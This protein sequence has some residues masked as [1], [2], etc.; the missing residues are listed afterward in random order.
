MSNTELPKKG[1]YKELA[2]NKVMQCITINF[3]DKSNELND[4]DVKDNSNNK[5]LA[6]PK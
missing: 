1:F 4:M 6:V 3:W 2:H 5:P